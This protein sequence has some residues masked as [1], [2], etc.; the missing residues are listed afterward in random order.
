MQFEKELGRLPRTIK[1]VTKKRSTS[2]SPL[3]ASSRTIVDE[4]SRI[5]GSGNRLVQD[6][7]RVFGNR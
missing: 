2:T 5:L 3:K 4:Q 7:S 1:V 6:E